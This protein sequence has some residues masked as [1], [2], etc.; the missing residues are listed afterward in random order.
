[1][2]NNPPNMLVKRSLFLQFYKNVETLRLK[3]ID[4]QLAEL[5]L[6]PRCVCLCLCVCVYV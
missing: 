2:P 6:Q 5:K 4:Q 3:E 1:M